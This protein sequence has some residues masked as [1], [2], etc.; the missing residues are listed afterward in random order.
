MSFANPAG[1][2]LLALAMPIVL[3]HLLRPRR[4]PRHVSSTFL[5][6]EMAEPVAAARPWQRLR[7][8]AL[9]F[10]QLLAV[11]LLALAVAQPVRKTSVSL[12]AHT[13]FL[14]DAS[15]S[16]AATDGHPDRLAD[17]KEQA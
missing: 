13:V 17:A 7:P 3:L 9:L 14:I 10:L 4:Q 12:A 6:S 15:G 16:M 8:T 5:W 1:L 2:A 11:L